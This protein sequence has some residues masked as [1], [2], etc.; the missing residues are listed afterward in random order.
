MNWERNGGRRAL[1][2]TL[3]TAGQVC[4]EDSVLVPKTSTVGE[5][6]RFDME[7]I[8]RHVPATDACWVGVDAPT[9]VCMPPGDRRCEHFATT[10]AQGQCGR[11]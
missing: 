2:R 3:K 5:R 1:L 10:V 8:V 7:D 4:E 9:G 6:R 11:G